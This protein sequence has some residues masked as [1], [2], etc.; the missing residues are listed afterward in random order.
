VEATSACVP[1]PTRL[2]LQDGR[3]AVTV[4]WTTQGNTGAGRTVPLAADTGAFWFFDP[5]NLEMMV[6]VLDGCS[7]NDRYWV[8]LSGLT[9][10]AVEVTV[11]DTATGATWTHNHPAGAALQ[12][13]LD[14]NA[15]EVCP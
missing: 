5:A 2:C 7:L 3:F 13:R 8:F 11:M 15:L 12:P 4:R 10:V 9:D 1:G 6:K 14:T